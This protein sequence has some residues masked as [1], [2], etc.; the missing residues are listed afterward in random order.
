MVCAQCVVLTVATFLVS[1]LACR[2]FPAPPRPYA[3][4]AI[5][6]CLLA[7]ERDREMMLCTSYVF[8]R[9]KK[10]YKYAREVSRQSQQSIV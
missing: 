3:I 10:S 2:M 5:Y 8:W 7:V 6:V 9:S 1:S 4:V